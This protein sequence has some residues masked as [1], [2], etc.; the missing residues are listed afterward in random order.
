MVDDFETNLHDFASSRVFLHDAQHQI[1]IKLEPSCLEKT[2]GNI[3]STRGD[4]VGEG[5][6]KIA[7]MNKN[8][9]SKDAIYILQITRNCCFVALRTMHQQ[10][11]STVF[12]RHFR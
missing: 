1:K 12:I 3:C 5:L 10:S 4:V 9:N 7:R 11:D 2:G 6:K 8:A